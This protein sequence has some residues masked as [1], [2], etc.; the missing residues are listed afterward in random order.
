MRLISK[1]YLH[2]DLKHVVCNERR[3]EARP[4][5]DMV[6]H[7]FDPEEHGSRQEVSEGVASSELL[8]MDLLHALEILIVT[9][10]IKICTC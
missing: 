7:I 10:G 8:Q 4:V 3:F 9:G 1:T 6:V 2:D 5:V